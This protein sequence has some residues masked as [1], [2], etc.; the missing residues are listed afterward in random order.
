[1]EKKIK[2]Q[3]IVLAALLLDLVVG[4][5]IGLV[6]SCA[7]R[8]VGQMYQRQFAATPRDIL[9]AALD[10]GECVYI[11]RPDGSLADEEAQLVVG[12]GKEAVH[13]VSLSRYIQSLRAVGLADALVEIVAQLGG[14]NLVGI[15]DQHPGT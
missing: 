4:I 3:D 15:D 10:G 6:D 12:I 7:Y 13:E 11:R 1:M 14:D 9:Y 5:L 8:V 2:T